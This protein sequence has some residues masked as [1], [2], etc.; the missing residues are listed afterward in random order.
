MELRL[1][2]CGLR[3]VLSTAVSSFSLVYSVYCA[4]GRC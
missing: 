3:A 2:I 1:S 4:Y